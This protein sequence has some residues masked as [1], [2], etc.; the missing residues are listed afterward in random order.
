MKNYLFIYV[1][2]ISCNLLAQEHIQIVRSDI[3]IRLLPSTSEA[4][5]GT[6]LLGEV[7]EIIGQNSKWYQVVLP[8]GQSRWIYKKLA[9]P[10]EEIP[11][12][13][14]ALIDNYSIKNELIQAKKKALNDSQ[15]ETISNLDMTQINNLLIDRYSLI[16]L[17][18]YLISPCLYK[19]IINFQSDNDLILR[20]DT[21]ESLVSVT[22]IDYD[23]FKID[24]ENY[25]IETRRC[26]KL[27]TALDAIILTYH[28]GGDFF[29]KLCFEDGYGTDFENCYNIKNIYA[30]VLNETGLVTLTKDGKI[31][32]TDLILRKTI[33][34]LPHSKY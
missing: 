4:I 32:T 3:N 20:K 8:S 27:G 24:S 6:A 25:Y 23:L 14:S 18:K 26:F 21:T 5:V 34:D 22:H 13:S 33:L 19:G 1:I 30:A 16:V 11:F 7:Y 15:I 31:K 17:Q 2:L 28:E 10:T 9:I 29:Q 12:L